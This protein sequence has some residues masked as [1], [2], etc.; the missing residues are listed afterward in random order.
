MVQSIKTLMTMFGHWHLENSI[1]ATST[2]M[3]TEQVT[4]VPNVIT[5]YHHYLI[6]FFNTTCKHTLTE[7]IHDTPP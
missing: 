3:A 4:T 1:D 6:L 7:T 5:R 2:R